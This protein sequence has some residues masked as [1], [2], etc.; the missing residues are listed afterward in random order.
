METT[1]L[2][3]SAIVP[4]VLEKDNYDIWKVCLKSYLLAED[5][6]DIVNGTESEPNVTQAEFRTW[7]VKNAKALHAIQISCGP[8]I[9]SN[10]KEFDSSKV[11][12]DH[13]AS[14]YQ[15]PSEENILPAETEANSTEQGITNDDY[16]Q[17]LPLFKFVFNN[18]WENAKKFIHLQPDVVNDFISSTKETAL[19]IA[20]V[21]GHVHIVEELVKLMPESSLE[22]TNIDGYTGLHLAALSGIIKMAKA[23]VEK[24]KKML[25]MRNQ[26]GAIP[27]VLASTCGHKEMVRYLYSVT[28]KEDLDPDTSNNGVS[29]LTFAIFAD[30]Y[31]VAL[32][33]LQHYPRL[34]TIVDYNGD[35]ALYVLAQNG[36]PQGFWHQW[37]YSCMHVQL[38]DKYGNVIRDIENPHDDPSHRCHM[39]NRVIERFL[40]TV[41][42]IKQIFDRK[43]MNMQAREILKCIC[44]EI[45]TLDDSELQKIDARSAIFEAVKYGNLDFIVQITKHCPHLLWSNDGNERGVFFATILHRQ[46]KI[47]N[48][49]Y[50]IGAHKR[51]MVACLDKDS[52]SGL[53]IAAMLAPSSQLAGIS[54]AALQMQRELQWFKVVENIVQAQYKEF[55]NTDGKTPRALFTEEHKNLV[56]EGEK[57]MKDTASSSMVVAALIATVM[58]TA[59]FTVPGGNNQNTGIPI[60]LDRNIFLVY[61]VSDALSLFSSAT[62]VLMFLG[63]L[64]S[65]YA[66]DDFLKSLPSRLMIGLAALFL[67]IVTMMIA[68]GTTLYIVLQERLSWVYIPVS[69]LASV[70]I[71]LFASLQFPLLVDIVYSTYGPGIFNRKTKHWTY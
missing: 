57:W 55:T 40:V 34:A 13:L 10:I 31:D 23:M 6:W 19:H 24:N 53:H 17:K 21:S 69:L 28:P 51:E 1:K 64:T 59:A 37:I 70:P 58:F 46:E 27:V 29:L 62:S 39:I 63:I 42:G 60:F 56:K 4:D 43:L 2:A 45:S 50:E 22:S 36:N 30:I 11:A 49:L 33:L 3:H 41:P 52:N 54:G 65:R 16:N 38:T 61:I 47:F 68:F 15:L 20:A 7:Q 71:T 25:G 12:W 35:S 26:S 14:T 48:F 8:Q 66:E 5:L 18:D 67:S 44:K 32:D 9:L